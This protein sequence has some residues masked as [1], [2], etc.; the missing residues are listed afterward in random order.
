MT[1]EET[2]RKIEELA[3]QLLNPETVQTESIKANVYQRSAMAWSVS[4]EYLGCSGLLGVL[5]TTKCRGKE[6]T[7]AVEKMH[8]M[9][10]RWVEARK[11]TS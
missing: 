4:V 6:P 7:K 2:L 11:Q 1:H 9:L 3:R 10:T 5:R 8:A